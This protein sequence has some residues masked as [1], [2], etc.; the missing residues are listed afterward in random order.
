MGTRLLMLGGVNHPH[1]EHLALGLRE[2]GFDVVVAG[3]AIPGLPVSVLER[4]GFRLRPAPLVRRGSARGAVQHVRWIRRLLRGG[5]A[6]GRARALAVRLRRASPRSPAPPRSSR[7]RGAR[8]S[9]GRVGSRTSRTGVAVR[10]S[11]L[12]M[13]DSQD[14]LDR[15]VALGADPRRTLLVNWGVD[16]ERFRPAAPGAGGAAR[17][18]SGSGRGR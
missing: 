18:G 2:R 6:R 4:E 3:D 13:A 1:V 9:T 11:A 16:L 17:R 12:V 14:L 7:W 10:R 15:V 5:A 8:T